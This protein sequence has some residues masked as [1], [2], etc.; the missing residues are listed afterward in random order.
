MEDRLQVANSS[1][2]NG[3]WK[4]G[5]DIADSVLREMRDRIASGDASG[6]LLAVAYMFRSIGEAGMGD[7][8]SGAWDF[9]IAQT[10]YPAYS[11]VDLQPYG[12]AGELLTRSRYAE[13]APSDPARR[14]TQP[15]AEHGAGDVVPPRKLSGDKPEYPL[16]KAASCI[17]NTIL[18]RT[19]INQQGRPESPSLPA[20]T[21]P[22]LGVAALD[23]V[24]T[25]RFEPATQDGKPVRVWFE[26]S[27]N[28][29]VRG[30]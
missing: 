30:C 19:I 29:H 16:A 1:L 5:R 17:E 13:S 26:L 10:L 3:E 8:E 7:A 25:W 22:V 9:G 6:D 18:V 11:K 12:A 4:K 2:K 20:G 24:R 23:A 27:V 14:P 15:P 21:D 28:F